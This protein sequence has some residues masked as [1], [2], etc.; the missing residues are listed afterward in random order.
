[1]ARSSRRQAVQ[2]A[3]RDSTRDLRGELTGLNMELEGVR[4]SEQKLQ[5]SFERAEEQIEELRGL[6]WSFRCAEI[7]RV[8][9]VGVQTDTEV[10]TGVHRRLP[11]GYLGRRGKAVSEGGVFELVQ[12]GSRLS[13]RFVVAAIVAHSRVGEY[14]AALR[15][16]SMARR[17]GVDVFGNRYIQTA[18]RSAVGAVRVFEPGVT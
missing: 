10:Q 6:V 15:V 11:R 17:V 1:M 13:P 18:I 14:G 12:E 2:R 9:R 3:V 16:F 5:C 7:R 4:L 8:A